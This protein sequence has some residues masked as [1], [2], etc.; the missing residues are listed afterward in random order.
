MS[1]PHEL[2]SV[3]MAAILILALWSAVSA[4]IALLYSGSRRHVLAMAPTARRRILLLLGGLPLGI[5]AVT[6]ALVLSPDVPLTAGHCHP[7]LGCAAHSPAQLASAHDDGMLG[8]AVAVT[9][10]L[11]LWRIVS[12][13]L[14]HQRYG[15][16]LRALPRR[17]DDRGFWIVESAQPLA[18][19]AGLW[20]GQIHL[21]ASLLQALDDSTL[22]VVLDHEAAH[23]RHRDNLVQLLVSLLYCP[24]SAVPARRLL[25]DLRECAEQLADRAAA[26]HAGAEHV[27]KALI[28]THR[29]AMHSPAPG[30]ASFGASSLERRVAALY[31]SYPESVFVRR[32]G[33][34]LVTAALMACIVTVNVA[35]HLLE[36]VLLWIG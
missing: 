14:G 2:E 35:H 1:L 31:A 28:R 20:R 22:R 33:A 23:A 16:I 36:D 29:L 3:L 15:A 21:S 6:T 12:V 4:L 13:G 34:V 30:Y 18:L 8:I 9:M 7:T 19:T 27:A 26:E 11:L 25:G 17:R 32:S 5:A 10:T 24:L